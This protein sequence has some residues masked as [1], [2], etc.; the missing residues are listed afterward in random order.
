MKFSLFFIIFILSGCGLLVGNV[1]PVEE[2]AENYGV[3]DLSLGSSEWKKL[4]SSSSDSKNS[5][6]TSSEISDVA[7]QSSH[8]ASIISLNSSCRPSY[9]SSSQDLKEF[10]KL[11]FMGISNISKK[12]ERE[13]ILQELP[14]LETTILGK[15][16]G[17][18][19]M[20]K[21]VV[22]RK[23]DCVY[24]LMMI[25]RPNLFQKSE[26]EFERFVASLRIK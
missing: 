22:L 8:T 3:L 21:A 15:L 19:M 5:S 2:K 12:S 13:L 26:G 11:L 16:N 4:S 25:A 14:A 20:L 17:E 7:F 18:S 10:T 6:P 1:K 23:R 24:D 9:E